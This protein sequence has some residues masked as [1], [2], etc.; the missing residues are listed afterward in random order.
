M[1]ATAVI[2][3][4]IDVMRKI[5]SRRMGS[6]RFKALPPTAWTCVSPRLLTRVTM[7][8]T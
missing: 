6:L 4:V 3:F 5:V 2:G 8:G 1:V 7:P